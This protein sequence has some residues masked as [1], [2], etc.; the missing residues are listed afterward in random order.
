VILLGIGVGLGRIAIDV[1]GDYG[2]YGDYDWCGWRLVEVMLLD[3]GV[4]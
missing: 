3:I 2:D 1:I 4:G